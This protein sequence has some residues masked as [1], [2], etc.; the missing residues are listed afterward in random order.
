MKKAFRF[1]VLFIALAISILSGA[2][3]S[4]E[5]SSTKSDNSSSST[6]DLAKAKNY[7]YSIMSS[8]YYWSS[9][10]PSVNADSYSDIFEYFD[11]LCVSNDRWSWMMDAAEYN[12]METGTYS[13]Y[14]GK[15]C[16]PYEYYG[17]YGI[18]MGLVYDNSPLAAQGVTRGWQLTKLDGVAVNTLIAAGTFNSTLDKA[19]LTF[20]YKDLNGTEHTFTTSKASVQ[21]SSVP[22]SAIFTQAD[23]PSLPSTAKVGYVLYTTFNSSMESQITNTLKNFKSSG[24]T[25]LIV[26]LRYN[27]G[28]DLNVC[29][30]IA[31]L[32]VPAAGNGKIFLQLKHNS[33]YSSY[34]TQNTSQYKFSRS[35]NS[36]DLSRIY[37]ITGSGTASASE[38]L[39]N[40]LKP[41]LT[42]KQVG[43]T[44]YGK[45]NGMY[46]YSYPDNS[47][48]TSSLEY[49]FLPICFYCVNSEGGGYF[50][51]G[52]VPDNYR[53]DDLYHDFGVKEDLIAACLYNIAT[54]SY[55][56]KPSKS[57]AAAITKSMTGG[58]RIA[59][60]EDSAGYGLAIARH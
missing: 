26:D 31:G 13:I 15:F 11:A 46:V 12:S 55:P 5:K 14:G 60:P 47:A 58:K 19:S 23:Y 44:T 16:Q 3:I 18:Y 48:G 40:G 8:I 39:M 6:T 33:K 20:T 28:G 57:A 49:V 32:L 24:I 9:S 4:C 41:F 22:K 35:T 53:Y 1:K 36:L 30:D 2:L 37:F 7:L 50:D 10:I 52:I 34:D 45:P 43:D 29:K 21:T 38:S 56:S 27:G 17:D 25:D 42:V 54:G 51:N 59:R